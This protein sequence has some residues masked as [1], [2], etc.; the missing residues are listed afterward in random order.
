MERDLL[1]E[2]RPHRPLAR[3]EKLHV[4]HAAGRFD[5]IEVSLGRV[6]VRDHGDRRPL[7]GD[8]LGESSHVHT[9]VYY[10]YFRRRETIL[11]H[12]LLAHELR[13]DHHGIRAAQRQRLGRPLRPE[14][15]VAQVEPAAD[16]FRPHQR[17]RRH[18]EKVRV[19]VVG[20]DEA[21][22]LALHER[23]QLQHN[24]GRARAAQPELLDRQL[25]SVQERPGFLQAGHHRPEALGMPAQPG[26]KLPD[27]S[28]RGELVDE[29]K[30][31]DR[32]FHFRP[33]TSQQVAKPHSANRYQLFV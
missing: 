29:V 23:G 28:I 3:A 5:Q 9:I 16:D 13:V 2:H 14:R 18:G 30:Y 17:R 19:V 10:V 7:G 24:A 8:R 22:A 26:Q 25:H 20:V 1:L 33:Q 21:H 31:A 6:E 32:L 4:A 12:A 15:P 27:R 11:A